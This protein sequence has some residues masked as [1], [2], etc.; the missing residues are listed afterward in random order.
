MPTQRRLRAGLA[1]VVLPALILGGCDG[2]TTSVPADADIALTFTNLPALDPARDGAL[3]IWLVDAAGA[4]HSAGKLT[5]GASG[6]VHVRSPIASPR[7][8]RVTLEPPGDTDPAP[9]D[10]AVLAG[11]FSGRQAHLR[12]D[13]AILPEGAALEPDPGQF[14]MFTPSDNY[15][16][17]YPSHEYAGVWLFNA[18]PLTTKQN[19]SWVRMT[20][21]SPGW[22]YEGWMVRDMGT[23]QAIWLSYGKF[24]PEAHGVVNQKDDTG[25]GPFSGVE[26]WRTMGD[27]NF[28]GDDWV[29]NPDNLPFPSA[30]TLPVNLQEK[31]SA[32]APRW[33]HVITVEPARDRGEPIGSERPLPLFMPYVDAFRVTNAGEP[34]AMTYHVEHLLSG[35]AV[36]R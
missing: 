2:G 24:L 4:A 22:V 18:R 21:L 13:G 34:Q 1:L 36:I 31:T 23:P 29:G 8:L 7:S 6:E 32:G 19:D 30:L 28:P 10:A 25:W 11:H 26:D 20:P 27:D 5:A 35:E 16:Y 33:T 15:L 9:S 14:T 17:G 12:L 3:E